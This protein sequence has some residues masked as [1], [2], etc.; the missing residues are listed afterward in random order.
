MKR[1]VKIRINVSLI[2]YL[3]IIIY[4]IWLKSDRMRGREGGGEKNILPMGWFDNGNN[5]NNNNI[6]FIFYLF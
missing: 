5:N 3:F 4:K 6:V 1:E 2:V